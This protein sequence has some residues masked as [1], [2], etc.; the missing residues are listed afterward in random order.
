MVAIGISEFTFGYAF[1]HEQTVKNWDDLRA[2]PILP[3]LYEESKKG[4]DAKLPRRGNDYYFQFKLTDYLYRRNAAHIRSG[5]YDG[6]YYRIAL[7][8]RNANRQHQRLKA[9]AEKFLNTYYVA[10]EVCN[11]EKFNSLFMN[12]EVSDGS[13]L[14]SLD[15][16]RDIDDSGQ[17][18]ITFQ[19]GI[20][21]WIEHSDKR[22]H[23]H[24]ILGRDIAELYRKSQLRSID[25]EY[26]RGIF[27]KLKNAVLE[28]EGREEIVYSA[29]NS[30]QTE[31]LDPINKLW[32]YDPSDRPRLEVFNR[33]SHILSTY[34]GTTMVI[35]GND[36]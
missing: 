2:V 24:S 15:Q 36:E 23:E 20:Q 30:L 25:D 17:H 6:P 10:P 4:W 26:I 35:V 8:R 22:F 33:I 1:L 29:T 11:M 13:R 32:N 12:R 18:Y 5:V 19:Q 7:Y 27:D 3:S 28:L 9:L 34:F 21:S 31:D 14:I 16:C